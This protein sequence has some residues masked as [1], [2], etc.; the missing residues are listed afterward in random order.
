MIDPALEYL[1]HVMAEKDWTA[2]DLAREAGVSHSTINRPLV[3]PNWP[4][5]ISRTTLEKVSRASGI[6]FTP[7][8]GE[9]AA[10]LDKPDDASLV[11]V[12]N[13]QASAGHGAL[14]TTEDIVERLAFPPDY[15]RHITKSHPRNLAIIGVKG[16]SMAP[17]LKDDDLVMIDTSKVDL[18]YEGMFVIKIDGGSALLVKR[19]GRASRR[20]YINVISDNPSHPAVEIVAE[21]VIPVGKV[22]WAGVKM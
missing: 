7:F 5:A 13:V 6:S 16:D 11:P 4:H 14:V 17:T 1:R 12:Y 10:R 21:D 15:L 22:V 3:T 20:G 2:A 9:P 19:I 8:F 18:S